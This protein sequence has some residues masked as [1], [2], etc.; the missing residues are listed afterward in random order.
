MTKLE[1][2][3]GDV[4]NLEFSIKALESK[5]T[6]LKAE[7]E[8]LQRCYDGARDEITSLGQQIESQQSELEQL[9]RSAAADDVMGEVS[10][11]KQQLASASES[12][13]TAVT[14]KAQV[15]GDS[16]NKSPANKPPT[17]SRWKETLYQQTH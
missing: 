9:R 11:L 10:S 16:I 17:T 14:S 7:K 1:A 3:R 8:E 2:G 13:L 4:S 15:K 12:Y 6:A 5:V